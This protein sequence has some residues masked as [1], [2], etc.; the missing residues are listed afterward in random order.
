MG[1]RGVVMQ[2][3]DEAARRRMPKQLYIPL[4]CNEARESMLRRQL[5]PGCGVRADLPDAD[6][7]KIVAHTAGYSGSDMRNLIQEAS[8]VNLLPQDMDVSQLCEIIAAS[9]LLVGASKLALRGL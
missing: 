8:Q 6:L 5:G 7:A 1:S 4:P 2:E 3:L 9:C